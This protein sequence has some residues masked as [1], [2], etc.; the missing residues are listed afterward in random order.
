MTFQVVNVWPNN[1]VLLRLI[2]YTNYCVALYSCVYTLLTWN[3]HW[4]CWKV[5]DNH[6]V[7]LNLWTVMN[8][9]HATLSDILIIGKRRR[10]RQGRRRKGMRKKVWNTR[11][12]RTPTM[13]I[14][15]VQAVLFSVF[16][17]FSVL[18]YCGKRFKCRIVFKKFIIQKLI[19]SKL[20]TH[21]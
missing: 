12:R 10:S 19:V 18:K 3:M 13:T 9:R 6:N 8:K 20:N 1:N 4:K 7:N 16:V 5:L 11:E 21:N 17:C 15:F 2:V 14:C